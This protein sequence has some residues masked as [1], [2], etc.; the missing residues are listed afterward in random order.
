MKNPCESAEALSAL[1]NK[2]AGLGECSIRKTY[3]P[4]LQQRL[5]ELERLKVFLDQSNDN[6]FLVEVPSGQIVDVNESA[7]RQ[8]GWSRKELLAASLF[9]LS[10][11]GRNPAI[12]ELVRTPPDQADERKVMVT[13]ELFKKEGGGFPA[14]LTLNRMRFR[15]QSYVLV[16]ARDITERKHLEEQLLQAQKM[17]AIG[18]LAGGVAHDFNN[19]LMIIMGYADML[20]KD[21]IL[22]PA[23]KEKVGHIMEAAERAAQLTAS[24]LAFSRKQVMKLQPAELNSIIVRVQKFLIRII[25]EDIGLTT[26]LNES[27]IFINADIG[28]IEQVLVN[29]AANARDAMP[30]GGTL[31]IATSMQVLDQPFVEANQL[32]E[33]G[34]YAV[35]TVSDTGAGMDEI[36]RLKAFEPFFTTKEQG[37]GTGLGM[38]IVYGIIKQHSGFINVYSEP[39]IGTSFRIY[40]PLSD[41]GA[42]RLEQGVAPAPPRGG[43]ETILVAE[44]EPVLRKLLETILSG[45]GYHVLLAENGDIAVE[46]FQTERGKVDLVLIDMIMPKMSGKEASE[47]IRRLDSKARVIFISGY[48]KEMIGDQDRFYNEATELVM[49]PVQPTQLLQ[50]VRE[51]LDRKTSKEAPPD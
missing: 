27:G 29:L 1:K 26:V 17:E 23:A 51:M 39:G 20:T 30:K 14:E 9:E 46:R 32:G 43:S 15:G 49:K 38:S 21:S 5:E 10:D 25:G 41:Q 36:T 2:L 6:L 11:A 34:S 3:Y 31:T 12:T 37:K 48:P 19:I 33:P 22:D 47:A 16:V 4:E 50:K 35:V 40:L 7:S 44:D 24:L 13:A 45:A 28:Q 18:Q 8:M 42:Y